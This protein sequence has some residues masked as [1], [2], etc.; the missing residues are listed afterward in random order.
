MTGDDILRLGRRA[1]QYGQYAGRVGIERTGM[2]DLLLSRQLA[3]HGDDIKGGKVLLLM[4]QD[5]AVHCRYA[6]AA[7]TNIFFTVPR[8]P[9]IEHPDAA[10]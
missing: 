5:D 9:S 6:S 10:G 8:S 3:H 2:T 4:Y 7:S 1:E